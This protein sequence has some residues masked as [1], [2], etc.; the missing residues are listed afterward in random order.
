MKHLQDVDH[1][2]FT[3]TMEALLHRDISPAGASLDEDQAQVVAAKLRAAPIVD[4]CA[5]GEPE[6]STYFFQTPEKPHGSVRYSTVRLYARG[7][8]LLHIDSDGDIYKLQRL[9][10]AGGP[11]TIFA[12][13]ADG[14]WEQR[15]L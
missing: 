4:N 9:Y 13:T 10:D 1:A 11:R 14:S 5:C 15:R 2:L 6:C 12:R 7:E 8:H 3:E